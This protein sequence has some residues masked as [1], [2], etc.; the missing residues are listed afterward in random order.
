MTPIVNGL[1][2]E[3]DTRMAFQRLDA[4]TN[5]GQSL[6]RFYGLRGHPS[7]AIVDTQGEKLWSG[8]GEIPESI[9]RTQVE[10][11]SQ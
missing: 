8:M 4:N 5:E 6:L 10:K 7:Y 9:L 1:E 3:F 2:R 11:Y